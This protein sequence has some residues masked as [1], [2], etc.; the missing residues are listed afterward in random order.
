[1]E[2]LRFNFDHPLR[3]R[4]CLT[5]LFTKKPKHLFLAIDSKLSNLVEIS[6]NI[7][8]KGKWMITLNWE[9]DNRTFSFI[10]Q[11]EINEGGLVKIIEE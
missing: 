5:Q 6:T 3:G 1:M 2:F 7:C 4:A 8:C 9:Y 10:H 11:F